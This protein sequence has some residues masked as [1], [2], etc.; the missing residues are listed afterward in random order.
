MRLPFYKN[1]APTGDTI[2]NVLRPLPLLLIAACCSA[3]LPP[4]IPS[5]AAKVS[6][7]EARHL[8]EIVCPGRASATGCSVCPEESNLPGGPWHLDT[9]TFGHFLSAASDDALLGGSGC[10]PHSNGFS[11]A[12]LLTRRQGRWRKLW[13]HSAV[14]AGDCKKL[15]AS[16]GRDLLLCHATDMH[17][18]VAEPFLYLLDPA[19]DPAAS[20]DNALDI[21]FGLIDSLQS[22]TALAD[23]TTQSGTIESVT[24]TPPKI[25]VTARL[26]KAA[27]AAKT[28]ESCVA[29][30][31]PTPPS[32]NTV[33]LRYHF[34]FTGQKI[35]PAQTNP[36]A[37]HAWAIAPTTSY[38][39]RK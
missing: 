38:S 18:G 8:L 28:L 25:A 22:C 20:P 30:P 3:A 23:G 14:N 36:P 11:G 12:Y 19:Q 27:I 21:F 39:P 7:A 6:P 16:D 9:V 5:G 35:T 15:P 34:L 2:F 26:G 37:D 4:L 1:R 33:L 24:I 32:L 17:Q 13:Y 10:E 29:S 31:V